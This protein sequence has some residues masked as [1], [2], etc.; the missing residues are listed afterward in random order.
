MKTKCRFQ[1]RLQNAESHNLVYDFMDLM[2]VIYY[3]KQYSEQ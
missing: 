3:I 2:D 1:K